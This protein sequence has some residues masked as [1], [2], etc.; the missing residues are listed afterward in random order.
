MVKA[1]MTDRAEAEREE[2]L[3]EEKKKKR[4]LGGSRDF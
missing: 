2:A 1:Y 4:L 3:E